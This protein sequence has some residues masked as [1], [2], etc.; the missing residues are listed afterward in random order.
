MECNNQII[1]NKVA[2]EIWCIVLRWVHKFSKCTEFHAQ[3]QFLKL[4]PPK[5]IVVPLDFWTDYE[6]SFFTTLFFTTSVIFSLRCCN[7]FSHSK[8]CIQTWVY[9]RKFATDVWFVSVNDSTCS[10]HTVITNAFSLSC[11]LYFIHFCI[12]ELII[13]IFFNYHKFHFTVVLEQCDLVHDS[14]ILKL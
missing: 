5:N 2:Q 9:L 14:L 13:N 4:K 1:L 12:F 10:T 8:Y 3:F 7:L 11:D 6:Y